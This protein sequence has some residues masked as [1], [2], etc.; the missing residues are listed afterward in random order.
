MSAPLYLYAVLGQAPPRGR[1]RGLRG[2]R[3]TFV[4]LGARAGGLVVAAGPMATVPA[5]S[6]SALRRHDAVVRRLGRAVPSVLPVRF[7]T[8][9]PGAGGLAPLVAGRTAALRRALRRVAGREQMTLRVFGP[10]RRPLAPP[11]RSDRGGPGTRYLA[12]RRRAAGAA[13]PTV[14]RLRAGL[15]HLIRDER[16]EP[17]A[18]PPLLASVYHLV[19][20]G[21]HRAYERAVRE[22]ACRLA[23]VR[24]VSSGPWAPYAFAPEP[25]AR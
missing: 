18:S 17:S 10:R 5:P 23:D 4:R 12:A 20:R 13:A 15:E 1:W 21:H 22:V 14:A 2:E 25:D 11:S 6:A 24:V 8:T 16:V 9:V 19:D 7:G 3:L